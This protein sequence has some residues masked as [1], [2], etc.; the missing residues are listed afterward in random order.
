MCS[1]DSSTL[2][3]RPL[4]T[5]PPA[6]TQ[7]HMPAAQPLSTLPSVRRAASSCYTT[8]HCRP[9]TSPAAHPWTPTHVHRLQHF[10]LPSTDTTTAVCSDSDTCASSTATVSIA[11]GQ[12][13]F[14]V[15]MLH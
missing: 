1:T 12:D 3:C 9:L 7:T 4:T 15:H 6:P 13:S 11:V 5:P 10:P 8:L 14:V 2:H